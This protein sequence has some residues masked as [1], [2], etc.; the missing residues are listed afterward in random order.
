ME[1]ASNRVSAYVEKVCGIKDSS[2]TT[3]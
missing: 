1:A 2:D 3:N